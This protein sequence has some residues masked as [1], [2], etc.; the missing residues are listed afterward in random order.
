M[1]YV[2]WYAGHLVESDE[3]YVTLKDYW[4]R[5]PVHLEWDYR[6]RKWV[7]STKGRE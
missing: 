1:K 6:R 3:P 7:R 2:G 4:D 5:F